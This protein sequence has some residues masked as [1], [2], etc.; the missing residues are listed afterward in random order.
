MTFGTL[1]RKME[2]LCNRRQPYFD[3]DSSLASLF[4]SLSFSK[5]QN[6]LAQRRRWEKQQE[7]IEMEKRRIGFKNPLRQKTRPLVDSYYIHMHVK[8]KNGDLFQYKSHQ[9][10][11]H[12]CIKSNWTYFMFTSLF[13]IY[14]QSRSCFCLPL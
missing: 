4:S 3:L 1:Y 8:L 10:C 13:C 5:Q 14:A 7:V 6:F 12:S 2:I 11:L 9:I